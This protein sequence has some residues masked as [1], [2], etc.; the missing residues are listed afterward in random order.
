MDQNQFEDQGGYIE[1]TG[2][3]TKF[4]IS[5]F[6]KDKEEIKDDGMGKHTTKEQTYPNHNKSQWAEDKH[7]F[8]FGV[9]DNIYSNDESLDDDEAPS[10]R[11][12]TDQVTESNQKMEAPKDVKVSQNILSLQHLFYPIMT[13]LVSF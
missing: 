3:P 11:Y 5:D 4:K 1:H 12:Q 2:S 7:G 13:I 9:I 6:Q 8:E 10:S